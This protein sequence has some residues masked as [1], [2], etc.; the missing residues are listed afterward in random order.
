MLHF[1]IDLEN[2]RSK[3]LQGAEYLT[4]EDKVTVFYSQTC[5][6]VT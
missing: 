4:A 6:Q 3:G 2:T 1:M 5:V